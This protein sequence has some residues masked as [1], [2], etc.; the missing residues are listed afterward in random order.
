MYFVA[1]IFE[2]RTPGRDTP[3]WK[4]QS[5]AYMPG[6]FGL[7]LMVSTA[8]YLQP[9]VPDWAKSNWY[10]IVSIISGIIIFW[11]AR[12]FLYRLEKDY[13]KDAWQ[14]PSKVYHDYVMFWGYSTCVIF[15]CVPVYFFTVP[16]FT[17]EKAIGFILGFG[18]WVI[19]NIWDFTHNEVPNS[20]QHPSTYEPI[21]RH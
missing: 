3:I 6:D 15:L 18:T 4:D 11:F 17:I 2:S 21:W 7:A 5:K 20:K 8:I 9:N 16:I 19:G 14:S 10:Y 12:K 13:D 1:W